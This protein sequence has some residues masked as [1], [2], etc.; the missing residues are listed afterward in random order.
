MSAAN[1]RLVAVACD[2]EVEVHARNSTGTDYV[3]ICGLDGSDAGVGQVVVALPPNALVNCVACI[4][5]V[6]FGK[7]FPSRLL[8]R[9]SS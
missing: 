9:S 1:N 5:I 3:S 6:R 2:G 4:Q 7:R 8:S